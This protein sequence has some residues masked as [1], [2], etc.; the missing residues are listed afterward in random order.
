MDLNWRNAAPAVIFW[1]NF[2]PFSNFAMHRPNTCIGQVVGDLLHQQ[3]LDNVLPN[4]RFFRRFSDKVIVSPSH[5]ITDM[6]SLLVQG[7][8]TIGKASDGSL[9]MKMYANEKRTIRGLCPGFIFPHFT[10]FSI[11]FKVIHIFSLGVKAPA[12][13]IDRPALRSAGSS[14]TWRAHTSKGHHGQLQW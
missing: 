6:S 7:P 14:N 13:L 5:T 12:A 10:I 2:L 8:V 9:N 1:N 4:G 3:Y 11:I